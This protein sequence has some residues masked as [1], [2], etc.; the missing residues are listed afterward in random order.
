MENLP[1]NDSRVDE[2]SSTF[3]MVYDTYNYVCIIFLGFILQYYITG[4]SSKQY[5]Y[6][7]RICSID[8]VYKQTSLRWAS[9][10]LF[11]I[12][13][14]CLVYHSKQPSITSIVNRGP[15]LGYVSQAWSPSGWLNPYRWA[16]RLAIPGW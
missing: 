9:V 11:D 4:V 5:I 13:C 7:Y 1:K 3:T 12:V 15:T 8:G 6:I 2:H 10:I 14:S 16:I